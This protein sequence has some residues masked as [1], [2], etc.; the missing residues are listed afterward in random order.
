MTLS[1]KQLNRLRQTNYLCSRLTNEQAAK[2]LELYG[3]EP[4][5]EPHYV[6]DKEDIWF[7]IRNMARY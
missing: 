4:G 1:E 7:T 5:D 3:D 2:L 6:W